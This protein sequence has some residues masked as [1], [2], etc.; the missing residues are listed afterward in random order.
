VS[1]FSATVKADREALSSN[2]LIKVHGV[3][4]QP[5]TRPVARLA[6]L[7]GLGCLL[8]GCCFEV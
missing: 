6:G 4:G 7:A 5:R 1:G 2:E 3:V 8:L